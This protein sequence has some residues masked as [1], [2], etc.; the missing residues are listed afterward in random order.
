MLVLEW[1]VCGLVLPASSSPRFCWTR[2][3]QK[4]QKLQARVHARDASSSILNPIFLF[5]SFFPPALFFGRPS[6]ASG[7][8]GNT[9]PCPLPR[10]Q[11]LIQP[12]T[13]AKERPEQHTANWTVKSHKLHGN[14]KSSIQ[15][16]AAQDGSRLLCM[17]RPL[18]NAFAGHH[19]APT[20]RLIAFWLVCP[21]CSRHWPPPPRRR[22][23]DGPEQ[24]N[25]ASAA[26]SRTPATNAAGSW[27]WP[28]V[29]RYPMGASRVEFPLGCPECL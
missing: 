26:C 5:F 17:T 3:Q 4:K 23:E 15:P 12:G 29:G 7:P 16:A 11:H 20:G 22:A 21:E 9:K 24:A 6:C 8:E 28:G 14:E 19:P 10:F 1:W 18:R 13:L 27:Q 25:D 2:A